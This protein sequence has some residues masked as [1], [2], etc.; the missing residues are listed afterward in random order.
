MVRAHVSTIGSLLRE[1][2]AVLRGQVDEPYLE[3]QFLLAAVLERPRSYLLAHPEAVIDANIEAVFRAWL[4][5]R[6]DGKPLAYITGQRQF[7]SLDLLV[8]E[9]TLIPRS[10]TELLV[11]RALALLDDRARSVLDLGTGS[12]AIALALKT[13]RP[14]LEV[15]GID[16]DDDALAVARVNG[17]RLAL[18]VSWLCSDW[19]S[20]LKDRRFD[21]IV[22]NPP[23]VAATDPHLQSGDTRFEPRHALAAGPDGLTSLRAII[24]RAGAYLAPGGDLLLEHGYDQ[25]P[26]VRR[27][28]TRAGFE[29]VLS[30][31]DLSHHERVTVARA[32]AT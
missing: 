5:A 27:C 21:M 32:V 26:A 29:S 20:E 31:R 13:E 15:T 1:S 12:G 18:D 8:N 16:H 25:A 11:E 14:D 7:W 19:F 30:Y 2:Q 22:S 23:Y 10:E 28:L 4:N 6:E 24:A 3:A 9:A 17:E